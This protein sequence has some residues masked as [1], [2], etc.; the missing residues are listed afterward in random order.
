MVLTAKHFPRSKGHPFGR[1]SKLLRIMKLTAFIL[2]SACMVAS[3]A[4]HSQKVSL[5]VHNASLEQVFTEIKKQTGYSFVYYKDDL[6]KA[7][8]VTL[9]VSNRTLQE[10][11]VLCFQNQPLSYSIL[12]NTVVIK[13]KPLAA[14]GAAIPNQLMDLPQPPIDIKGRVINENGEPMVVTVRVK[15]TDKATSTND[16]GEFELKGVDENATLVLTGVNIETV[17][18][19]VGG[20]KVLELF[21]RTRVK[22]GEAVIINTGYDRIARERFVGSYAQLDS[23][24]YH[25]RAGMNIIDRLDGTV[26]GVVFDRK[27]N[28]VSGYPIQ[29]R[30]ISTLRDGNSPSSSPLIVIDNFPMDERFDINTINPN[31][32]ESITV[33]RDAAASSIWGTRAGNGVIVITTKKGKFNQRF[34]ASFSSNITVE[35]KPDLFFFPRISP[36]DFIDIELMLFSKNFY[37]SAINNITTRP[38]I[39]P[40]VEILARRRSGLISS[41]DSTQQIDA[42]RNF[43]V[44][45]DL[46]NYVYREAIRQQHYLSFS[47][48]SNAISYQFSAGYNHSLN[49]IQGSRGDKQYTINSNTSIRVIKNLELQTGINFSQGELRNAAFSLPNPTSPYEQFAD[50]NGNALAIPFT[51]R[52]GYID[53]A[54]AGRLLNW[55]YRPL[56]EIR[57]TNNKTTNRF[58]RLNLGGS[59]KINNWLKL[60][61]L[62]QYMNSSSASRNIKSVETWEA[63]DFIN[64]FTNFNQTNISLRYP[65]PVGG[66]LDLAHVFSNSHNLRGSVSVDKNWGNGQ[67]SFTALIGT[68]FSEA[69][70]YQDNQRFFG[71]DDATGSYRTNIDFFNPYPRI[72]AASNNSSSIIPSTNNSFAEQPFNRFISL[73]AN[74]SYTYSQRYTIYASARRDGANVFGINTN[75]KWK[76]LWSI[77]TSWDVSKEKFYSLH[78]MPS[79]RLRG[80]YG[81]TGNVNNLLTG[82]LIINYSS[83]PALFTNLTQA[84]SGK[85]PNPDLKWEEN[86]MINIGIDFSLFRNTISG[87]LELYNKK[88][89]DLISF[90]PMDPTSGVNGFPF[91]FASMKGRGFDLNVNTRNLNGTVKWSS[92]FGFSYSKTIVTNIIQNPGY[93]A[94]DFVLFGLNT[95]PGRIAYGLSSYRWAG[96]DPAT[97]DP[98]GILNGQVSKSYTAIFN[99]SVQHQVFHGSS[100]PLYSGFIRNEVSW[101]GFSISAIITGRFAFYF[102]QPVLNLAYQAA[103]GS[104]NYLPDYYKRWQKPGDEAYTHVPSMPYPVPTSVSQRNTFYQSA[105]I[106]VKRGDNIRLQDIRLAYQWNNKKNTGFPLRSFQFFLYPNNLN[107]LLW[108]ADK[109]YFDPN[110]SG[111]S[112]DVTASPPPK[113][114]TIGLTTNF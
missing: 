48:G 9:V 78:W 93:R 64:R 111:V 24:N 65:V 73:F 107:I 41:G 87:S 25:R 44:R 16:N 68:E 26:P 108:R 98:Q 112:S 43:D 75:N 37:N 60:D 5:S 12:E 14:D 46:N 82:K 85:V 30:G 76:P 15:G 95:S 10:V 88:S 39:S 106:H 70:G 103:M 110:F 114:W 86:R 7:V 20:K 102:R 53:T 21:V 45:N 67:H 63:R 27:A 91:N 81:Y 1:G 47:G 69:G 17:E 3:A 89:T 62:Y 22:E 42:L 99:D 72:Y 56:D 2:L 113:T 105:E 28:R 50:G 66:L 109:S 8:K 90:L 97:G 80:S 29:I 6:K 74:S 18:W 84:F 58:I 51:Y 13:Q 32:V 59:Y 71:Y 92:G 52:Q 4:G 61:V 36:S 57:L 19:K 94:Q 77:G 33:L 31:D 100:I 40:V 79:L 55:Q 96:L 11:L 54:G 34:Q 83:S 38:I 23:A 35:E 49:N 101:K 104:N